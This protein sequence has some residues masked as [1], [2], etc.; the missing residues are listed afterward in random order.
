MP[1]VR[2]AFRAAVAAQEAVAAAHH[3]H[4]QAVPHKDF[5]DL[6]EKMS[7]KGESAS[8]AHLAQPCCSCAGVAAEQAAAAAAVSAQR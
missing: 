1:L 3:Q 4:R 6:Y 8:E 5:S 7:G 2:G